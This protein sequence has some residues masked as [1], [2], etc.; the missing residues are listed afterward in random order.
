MAPGHARFYPASVTPSPGACPLGTRGTAA[1]RPPGPVRRAIWPGMAD[2]QGVIPLSRFHAVL[3]RARGSKRIE[4]LLGQRD[5]AAAVA[6]L[7]VQDLYYLVK[8]V[9]PA[10]V[11]ELLAL[12]TPEQYQGFLDL[13]AWDG[14]HLSAPET[15]PWLE[16]LLAA[17]PEK[18]TQVVRGLDPELAALLLAR[19]IR[20][21]DI[22]EG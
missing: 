5:P 3:A 21:Y 20:V 9:G 17:G 8:E 12:A 22:V 7:P 18:L 1:G 14:E 6:E 2:D 19:H 15:R 13:D 16:A 11:H 4:L 10:D